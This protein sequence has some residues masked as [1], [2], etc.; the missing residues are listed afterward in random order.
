MNPA[1][2]VNETLHE[3][4][5][6]VV[7]CPELRELEKLL[8]NF[9]IFRVLRFEHGEIRHS[10]VLSWLF[11]PDESH[12]LRDLFLR[13]WLM[14]VFHDVTERAHIGVTHTSGSALEF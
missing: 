8:G 3:L 1:A 4:N 5:A 12:G 14:R 10:N 7:S 6:L 13:R 11:D 2:T 9:N